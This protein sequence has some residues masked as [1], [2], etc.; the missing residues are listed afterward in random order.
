LGWVARLWMCDCR[1]ELSME[2]SQRTQRTQLNGPQR[3]PPAQW[4][5]DHLQNAQQPHAN[6]QTSTNRGNTVGQLASS[7]VLER[8][9]G[10]VLPTLLGSKCTTTADISRLIR[11]DTQ[12]WAPRSPFT[13]QLQKQGDERRLQRGR[14]YLDTPHNRPRLPECCGVRPRGG[15][16]GSC[17]KLACQYIRGCCKFAE[18]GETAPLKDPERGFFWC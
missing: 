3:M 12:P 16:P 10:R 8:R 5:L 9:Q 18:S 4:H 7:Q 13:P 17:Q 15:S 1:R 2:C 6:N 11:H 14:T